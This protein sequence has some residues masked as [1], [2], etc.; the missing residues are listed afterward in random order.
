MSAVVPTVDDAQKC[1][2]APNL[3]ER[4]SLDVIVLDRIIVKA[5]LILLK[6]HSAMTKTNT[7]AQWHIAGILLDYSSS[8]S[9]LVTVFRGIISPEV[10]HFPYICSCFPEFKNV[11]F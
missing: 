6:H 10:S 7:K 5:E 8:T 2:N 11:L 9:F 1:R 3:L 4:T